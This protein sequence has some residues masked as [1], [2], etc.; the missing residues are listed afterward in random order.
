VVGIRP[1]VPDPLEDHGRI[2]GARSREVTRLRCGPVPGDLPA[3]SLG[4]A[5]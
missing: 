1:S 3:S 4:H 2:L 5:R